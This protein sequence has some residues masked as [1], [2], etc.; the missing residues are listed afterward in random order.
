[1][2]IN[3]T[4]CIY[5]VLMKIKIIS[6]QRNYFLRKPEFRKSSKLK[7][8]FCIF[9]PEFPAIKSFEFPFQ[10]IFGGQ[11]MRRSGGNDRGR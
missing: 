10:N 9:F 4:F 3:R 6:R 2:N 5:N 11:P 1:M 8:L 7:V